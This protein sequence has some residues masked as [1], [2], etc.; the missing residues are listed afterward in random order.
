[1]TDEK[2]FYIDKQRVLSIPIDEACRA[3]GIEVRRRNQILCPAHLKRMGKRNTNYGN[4]LIYL[5]NNRYKCHSCGASGDVIGL[6]MEAQGCGFFEAMYFLAS[7]CCP[8]AIQ[9]HGDT[10]PKMPKRC[11]FTNEE[12]MLIGCKSSRAVMPFA[13]AATAY[14]VRHPDDNA[15]WKGRNVMPVVT[16]DG[17]VLVCETQ[18]LSVKDLF[19]DDPIAFQSIVCGKAK[20]AAQLCIDMIN[21]GYQQGEYLSW[22]HEYSIPHEAFSTLIDMKLEAANRVL[23]YYKRKEKKNGSKI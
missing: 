12:L 4:C 15:A 1:M 20:T 23:E 2:R 14:E 13:E 19:R 5:D 17:N 22:E 8:D 3:N 6:T 7:N 11:P 9:E 16:S 18:T 10:K 21:R